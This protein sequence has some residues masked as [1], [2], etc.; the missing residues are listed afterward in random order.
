MLLACLGLCVSLGLAADLLAQPVRMSPRAM[1]FDLPDSDD[2]TVGRG[3]V[4]TADQSGHAVVAKVYVQSGP[5]QIVMLPDGELVARGPEQVTET[6]RPFEAA[7]P[8]T[9]MTR[10]TAELGDEFTLEK[11]R[12]YVYAYN[13]SDTFAAAT[14]KILESMRPGVTT[15]VERMGVPTS[16][17]EVALIAVI[18][19]TEAEFQNYRRMPEGVVAYYDILT[20]RIV[21]YEESPLFRA[22]PQLATQQ[23]ISTIAHEGAHQILHN[24]G[25]QKR[26]SSW[27]IWLSEGL[28]EYFAPTTFGRGLKWKGAGQINDLRMLEL[29]LYIKS[30]MADTPSGQLVE[31]TVSAARLTSTGYA[32]AWSLTH[33]LATRHREK[34]FAYVREL[35]ALQ[36]LEA[37]GPIVEP[38]IVPANVRLFQTYFGDDFATLETQL[39]GHLKKQPYRDPFAEYPHYVATLSARDGRR[40]LREAN[41]FH[42]PRMADVWLSESVRKLPDPARASA[43]IRVVEFP[44]RPVAEQAAR[45]FLGR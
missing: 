6:E 20:N 3:R 17:P 12:N 31:D 15:Y 4:V 29:E 9:V 23:A 44:N 19:R 41:I 13:C 18:F 8:E 7:T 32:A 45:Q 2:V 24:I 40:E 16:A 28:A 37:A 14:S 38:G 39:V 21:M 25:L 5:N 26:L 34:F 30:R 1:G 27:P 22:H 43:Q 42:S 35:S 10:L 11:T 33:W 36:P